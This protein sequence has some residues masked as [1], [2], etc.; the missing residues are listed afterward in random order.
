MNKIVKVLMCVGFFILGFSWSFLINNHK[1]ENVITI[2]KND[3]TLVTKIKT[4]EKQNDLLL[5]ELQIREGEISY[6]GRKYDELKNK[7]ND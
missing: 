3:T 6:W 7:T 2:T 5:D 4:L 1:S